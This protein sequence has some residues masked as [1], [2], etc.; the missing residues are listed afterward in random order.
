MSKQL[1]INSQLFFMKKINRIIAIVAIFVGLSGAFAFKV[2]KPDPCAG[3]QRFYLA[4]PNDF[5]PVTEDTGTE[6]KHLTEDACKYYNAG[7]EQEP[8]MQ[9]CDPGD[10][11]F[12]PYIP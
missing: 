6:C 4:G 12:A 11:G 2:A 7:T 8:D 3:V 10:Y 5:E 9:P 1:L